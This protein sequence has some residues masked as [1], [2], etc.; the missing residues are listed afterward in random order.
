MAS[1]KEYL[2]FVT[3]N[4]SSIGV[5]YR[6]MMGEFVL[7]CEGKVVGGIYDDRL[8]LKP[9]KSALAILK[10]IGAEAQWETPYEGAKQ[11]IAADPEDDL[12]VRLIEAIAA[13]LKGKR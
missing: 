10:E 8:L 7:Y 6:P 5:T 11:M 4:L 12:T 2:I 1:S 9:T 13:D 3:E